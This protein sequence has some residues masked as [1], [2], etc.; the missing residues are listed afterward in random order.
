MLLTYIENNTKDLYYRFNVT[1]GMQQ[2]MLDEW[3]KK[4]DIKIYTDSYLRLTQSEHE[5]PGC[6]ECLFPSPRIVPDT[7]EPRV[8]NEQEHSR[9]LRTSQTEA[10]ASLKDKEDEDK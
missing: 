5:I 2:I 3:A 7:Q 6:I 9:Q 8:P 10:A 1:K 4:D